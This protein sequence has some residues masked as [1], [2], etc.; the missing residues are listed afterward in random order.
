MP[1]LVFA[2]AGAEPSTAVGPVTVGGVTLIGPAPPVA[3]DTVA[4]D[5]AGHATLRATRIEETLRIDGHLDESVYQSVQP[6]GGFIQTEPQ[7]G[8][9]ATEATDVWIFFDERAIYVAARCWDSAPE[10]RWV[11][12]EMRRDNFNVVRNEN[13]AVLLDTYYDHRNGFVFELSPIGGVYDASVTNE[14]SPGNPE[15]NPIWERKAGRFEHGWIAEMAIPFKS[16]RYKPGTPQVWGFNMRRTVRWKNEESFITRMVPNPGSPIFQVSQEGVLVGVEVPSSKLNLEMKPYGI[17]SMTTDQRSTPPVLNDGDA[18]AGFDVKYGVSQNLTADFTYNTDFA[19]VEVDE[20]Q[21]NLTR[22]TL[23]F[24]EKREF[25]LEG[26]GIYDFGGASSS[27]S[28]GGGQ[29]LTPLL[30]FSRRIGLNQV[31]TQNRV[32]PINAGGRLTGKV[33]RTTIGLLNVYAGD[34]P[35]VGGARATDFSVVRL[36]RDLFRRSSVG[37][38]FTGR[39]ASTLGSGSSESYGVDTT[40]GLQTNFAINAYVATTRSPNVAGDDVSYRGDFNYNAD[41]YGFEF[42]RL[43]VGTNFNPDVGFLRRSGFHSNSALLR[44]SPRPRRGHDAAVRR[45]SYQADFNYLTNDAGRLETRTADAGFGIE[46]QNSDRLNVQYTRSYEY[47]AVPFSIVT[48]VK[49]PVGG[50]AFEEGRVTMALGNQRRVSGSVSAGYGSFYDGHRTTASYSGGR[51]QMGPRFANEPSISI[52]WVDLLVGQFTTR[53]IADRTTFTLTPFAFISG[54]VQYNFGAR[55][56]SSNV[57]FRWE[58]RPGSELFVVY[59]DE[60]DTLT[61]GFPDLKNRALVVKVNRMLRM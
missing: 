3:P 11:A 38:L 15:W 16:L 57:R 27:A 29:G 43:V 8:E 45:F 40:I 42:E 33:G 7:P 53:L 25:F 19:Q 13:V 24:P 2:Q 6:I 9:P 31:G 56:V 1:S 18:D 32:V 47:L 60:R 51:I 41:R 46:F 20:Q 14:R 21:V 36:R 34:D 44:F 5:A 37:L 59:T 49:I 39:S 22:F 58:Y 30:F 4:R 54:L 52:N 50:Y 26:Q 10:S 17:S 55:S 12:N 23:F 48:G 35:V 28:S 61:R